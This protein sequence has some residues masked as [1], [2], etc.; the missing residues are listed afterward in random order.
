MRYSLTREQARKTTRRTLGASTLA[1]MLAV[2]SIAWAGGPDPYLQ[3]DESWITISGHVENVQADRFSLNYGDGSIIV[4]MDDGDRDADGYKLIRGDQVIVTGRIDDDFFT[5]TT[6]EAGSVYVKNIETTFL[7]SSV[8][9]ESQGVAD[10]I[11]LPPIPISRT[12]VSGVVTQV[13]GD[14][15]LINTG[16]RML[17]VDVSNMPTNPLDDEGYLKID[18]GDRVKVLGQIDVKLF[19]GRELEA[20]TVIEMREG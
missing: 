18:K 13:N 12:V 5:L 15:F 19:E 2:G 17:R 6:I 7:A 20:D 3:A 11:M 9:E 10:S 14:D 1:L 8:D 4:E 16:D